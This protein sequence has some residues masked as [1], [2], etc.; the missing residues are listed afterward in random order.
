MSSVPSPCLI[1]LPFAYGE[2][3]KKLEVVEKRKVPKGA[4]PWVMP[5]GFADAL[6]VG[7][8]ARNPARPLFDAHQALIQ[9]AAV[10]RAAVPRAPRPVRR[11][12]F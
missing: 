8:I 4:D 3:A 12:E 9:P 10:R 11:E 7:A 2:M 5:E 6:H 1:D